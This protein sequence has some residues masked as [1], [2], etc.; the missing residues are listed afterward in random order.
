MTLEVLHTLRALSRRRLY[1]LTV[2]LIMGVGL[3]S[4]VVD[5]KNVSA[6]SWTTLYGYTSE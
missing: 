2:L 6:A 1:T 5:I 3:G 4:L